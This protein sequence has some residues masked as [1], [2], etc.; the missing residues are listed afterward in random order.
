MSGVCY[1]EGEK[2]RVHHR[3]K[4]THNNDLTL[5]LGLHRGMGTDICTA[6]S[7]VS[8][9]RV[10]RKG[11]VQICTYNAQTFDVENSF[12]SQDR[13][14]LYPR[15]TVKKRGEEGCTND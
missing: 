14:L 8:F 2:G 4:T 5:K 9:E 7:P 1:Q 13:G 10:D 12:N 6:F 11:S 15:L 3:A